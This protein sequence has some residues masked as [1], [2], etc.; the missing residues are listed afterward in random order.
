[1]RSRFFGRALMA[2][3]V[4]AT[5]GLAYAA[6][7]PNAPAPGSDADLAQRVRHE[8]LTYPRYTLWDD[9]A[10]RVSNGE[11][12]LSGAVTQPYK[13]SEIEGMVKHIPGVVGVA[14]NIEVLPL[15][16]MDDR[17][18]VQVARAIFREPSL[19]RYAAGAIPAIHIIVNN[20]H[21][22]LAGV[23]MNAMDKQIAGIRA[24]TGLSFGSV[25][26]NLQ[27]ETPSPG[28]S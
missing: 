17:L 16:P 27:V 23:V 9:L 1:M 13:K 22:T 10:Y 20:G 2:A 25:V 3:A 7:K 12:A 21:V 15:S 4:V 11:V 14:D 19:S 26:N 24:N 28:K 6:N 8:I 18:R 5:A